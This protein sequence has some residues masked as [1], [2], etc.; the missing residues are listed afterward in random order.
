[1]LTNT[2]ID[3]LIGVVYILK[4]DLDASID[5]RLFRQLELVVGLSRLKECGVLLR[6][7]RDT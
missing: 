2:T 1:M 3:G 5:I 6:L 4:N 7:L